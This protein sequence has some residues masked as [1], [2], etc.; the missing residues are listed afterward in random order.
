MIE[1]IVKGLVAPE[2]DSKLE[3]EEILETPTGSETVNKLS[4]G[5][6][7]VLVKVIVRLILE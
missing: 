3:G 4:A 5:M 6:A 2:I 7:I 1:I